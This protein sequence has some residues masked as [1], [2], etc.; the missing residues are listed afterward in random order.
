[1]TPHDADQIVRDALA[2]IAP[3]LDPARFSPDDELRADLDLDSMDFL[4]LVVAI[5]ETTGRDIPEHD[6]PD[7]ATYGALVSYLTRAG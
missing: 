4:N 1:M 2:R 5:S 7:I 6:Y 3:E